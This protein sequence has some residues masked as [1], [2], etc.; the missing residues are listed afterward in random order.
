MQNIFS[1]YRGLRARGS[2]EFSTH[3]NCTR[4]VWTRAPLHC[5]PFMDCY[6]NKNWYNY[7]VLVTRFNCT[8]HYIKLSDKSV[9]E[10]RPHVCTHSPCTFVQLSPSRPETALFSGG[11]G[12]TAQRRS[13]EGGVHTDWVQWSHSYRDT[14]EHMTCTQTL[15]GH[16]PPHLHHSYLCPPPPPLPLLTLFDLWGSLVGGPAGLLLGVITGAEW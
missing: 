15:E 5:N 11:A 1:L 13:E 2:F 12:H 6:N 4:A 16:V 7:T 3:C 9:R 10:V 14:L 8:V